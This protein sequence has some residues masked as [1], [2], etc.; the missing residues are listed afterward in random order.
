MLRTLASTTRPSIART[1]LRTT[2]VRNA[3]AISSP[4]LMKLDQRWENMS[5]EEQNDIIG[6]LSERQK[7]SWKDLTVEEKKAAWYISYG[8]WGPR[9]PIHGKGDSSKIFWGVIGICAAAGALFGGYQLMTP[10]LPASMSKEWQE[11]S[12]EILKKQNA[13]PFSG[14]D[15]VQSPSRGLPEQDDE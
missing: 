5:S 3:H 11:A 14:Y 4:T 15:Q 12:N 9:R 1:A 2:A 6:Q 8:A 13:N 7:G 10:P